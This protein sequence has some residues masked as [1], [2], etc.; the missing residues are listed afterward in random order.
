VYTDLVPGPR[1][2]EL[3]AVRNMHRYLARNKEDL[4]LK[5]TVNHTGCMINRTEERS[6][7]DPSSSGQIKS[8]KDQVCADFSKIL[9]EDKFSDVLLKVTLGRETTFRCHKAILA[10]RSPVFDAMFSGDFIENTTNTVEIKDIHANTM[11]H[12][13][14]FL[15]A[16]QFKE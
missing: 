5:L 12:F 4:K 2:W 11:K 6:P 7:E 9:E 14:D 3:F 8:T 13:L 16:G 15:Y 1:E 10:A